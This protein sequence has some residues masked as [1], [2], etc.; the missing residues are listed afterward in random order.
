MTIS[1]DLPAELKT[2]LDARLHGLS[3]TDAAERSA[4]ISEVYRGGGTSR[5]IRSEARGSR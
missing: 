4:K 1:P 3:R 2:A 5:A